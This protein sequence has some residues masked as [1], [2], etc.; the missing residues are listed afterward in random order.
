MFFSAFRGKKQVPVYSLRTIRILRWR[1]KVIRA[2]EAAGQVRPKV[3]A[4]P[5]YG[6]FWR[7]RDIGGQSGDHLL[8]RREKSAS[9]RLKLM[10]RSA[11][12]QHHRGTIMKLR[13]V[14]VLAGTL[15][16]MFCLMS[17][18]FAQP[19]FQSGPLGA[20]TKKQTGKSHRSSSANPNRS[21]NADQRNIRPGETLVLADIKGA[22]AIR[23]MWVTFP[24][25]RPD[26]LGRDGKADHSELVLRMY[27]DGATEPAVEAPFGDFFA[28]GFGERAEINSMP[29]MVEGGDAYNCFWIMPFHKSARIEVENQGEKMSG[30][31]YFQVDYVLEDS[32]PPDTPYFCAQ[33]R[34]EFPTKSGHDYLILDAEGKGHYVGTVL[35]G[36]AR[37]PEWFGE[38]DEKFYID[39]D[40]KPTIQG[41][42]TE[43]YALNAWGMGTG[44]YPYFGVSILEGEW[45]MVGWKT[46]IYRWHI[47]EPIHFEK[48][49]RF[50]IE[51]TGWITED[52]LK[53]GAN[54]G[55]VERN[56]DF[57]TVAFW[58]Q[59]GQPKRFTGKLPSAKERKLPNLDVIIEGKDMIPSLRKSENV[60]GSLQKGYDWTG[61]G[62]IFMRNNQV[63]NAGVG[64]WFEVDFDIAKEEYRQLTLR[65][66]MANDYGIYRIFCD[67]KKLTDLNSSGSDVIDFYHDGLKIREINLGSHTLPVG[68]HTLRFECVGKRGESLGSHFGLDSVRLRQRWDVKREAPADVQAERKD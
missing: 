28:A 10:C 29:I 62:Q 45:G 67:D 56:D 43:D 39:G 58:Y 18:A 8:R 9:G 14:N 6:V 11:Y 33:Y 68:T 16:A 54:R 59:V 40:T 24:Q 25:P 44:C 36:R 23:H 13:N 35:S 34:Q 50:E 30:S 38:G 15:A 60:A 63:I 52:E 17:L 31:F 32:L 53:E 41:T 19:S 57:A 47:V 27:W 4:L 26:W 1:E 12:L 64:A 5:C 21:S 7:S 61:D 48:S 49:L 46:T 2:N 3:T 55:H 20:L 51:D 37:S 65:T 22:G 66:T 42:G